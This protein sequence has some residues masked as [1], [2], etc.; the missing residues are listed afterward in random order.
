MLA[1]FQRDKSIIIINTDKGLGPGG[2]LLSD[3]TKDAIDD[4]LADC[5]IYKRLTKR[6][7]DASALR[8]K[9]EIAC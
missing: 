7:A 3:Y 4:H 6:D 5:R 8:I 1:Q 2:R 9:H